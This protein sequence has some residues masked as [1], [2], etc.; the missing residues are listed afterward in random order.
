MTAT[1]L[2]ELTA[3]LQDVVTLCE[4]G[5]FEPEIFLIFM[6]AGQ[7]RNLLQYHRDYLL[8]HATQH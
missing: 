3:L 4:T 8:K 1:Q 6:K 2:N 5:E 7:P